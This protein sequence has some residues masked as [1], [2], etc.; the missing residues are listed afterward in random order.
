MKRLLAGTAILAIGAPVGAAL[1]VSARRTAVEERLSAA[2]GE[3]AHIGGI[4]AALTGTVRLTDVAIGDVL[5]ADSIEASV[6]LDSLLAGELRADEIRVQGPRVALRV[7]ADGDSDLA[8]LLRRF[9]G[10]SASGGGAARGHGPSRVRRIIVTEGSLVAHVAGIGDLEADDVELVPDADGVRVVTGAVRV[11]GD[12]GP[13]HTNLAFSRAAADVSLP[14]L[15]FRRVLAVGGAGSIA[16]RQDAPL[17]VHDLAAGRLSPAG[18]LQIR[19]EVDDGGAAR[20][21]S[22][23]VSPRDFTVAIRGERVPLRAFASLA[24][25]G[26]VLDGA[27][28]TGALI[29]HRTNTDKLALDI[30]GA[31]DGAALDH[32]AI[33]A[34][35]V[36]FAGALHAHATVAPDA[37]TVSEATFDIGAAHVRASGW[38]RRSLPLAGQLDVQLA[39]AACA[40]LLATIPAQLR[41]PL[42]GLALDGSVGGRARLSLDLAAPDGEGVALDTSLV[43]SCAALA[44]PPAADVTKLAE[45]VPPLRLP[46][47]V[48]GAFIAAEDAHFWEHH[49]FDEEQIAR[50]LEIDLREQRVA[51]GGSTISQQLVKNAFLSQRRSLDRKLQEAILTWR[52]E[53][54][55]DKHQILDRYLDVIELGPHVAGLAA[56]ARHWFDCAPHDLSIRQ[57]AFLAALTSEPQSMSRRVR[58]AGGLDAESLARVDVVLRNMKRD[59]IITADEL[60]AAKSAPLRFA[61]SAL[62]PD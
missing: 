25:R 1:W 16:V 61:K 14:R 56:A 51:R 24:P 35:P 5:A 45:A 31:L 41:V 21:V 26:L 7:D 20:P 42:D 53:A 44:E 55:L 22:L 27:R 17:S 50:S 59:G 4:D 3:R 2:A 57:S 40:D 18:A 39:P 28:A 23:E 32:P 8:R 60:D 37:V 33:A 19:G 11:R 58:R 9:G 13:V 30:D 47:H 34:A 12:A 46:P 15:A 43:G 10:G 36:P 48:S 29:V 54:R 49:G 62:K 6:G 52:L 38:L